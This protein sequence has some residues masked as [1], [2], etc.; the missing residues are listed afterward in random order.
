MAGHSIWQGT[1]ITSIPDRPKLFILV[2]VPGCGKSTW[3]KT[4]LSDAQIVSSDAIREELTGDA[5]VQDK[6]GQV[7]N[8]FHQR[9]AE[10]LAQGRNA[11]ADSTALDQFARGQLRGIAQ[12][13]NA[14]T[15][16]ILFKN[17]GQALSRNRK[18]ERVVPDDVMARMFDK[19]ESASA[20]IGAHGS[21]RYDTI[22]EIESVG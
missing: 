20:E 17:L 5:T 4:F 9:L 18:R 14:E 6:N 10:A 2:G 8:I 11:V 16:V 1:T 21:F 13:F 19:F 3:A 12:T 15:H 7:F 22:T